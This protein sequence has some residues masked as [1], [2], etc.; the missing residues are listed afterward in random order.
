M[1]VPSALRCAVVLT[2]QVSLRNW[3]PRE[4]ERARAIQTEF[5]LTIRSAS[6]RQ[7]GEE[8]EA[9]LVSLW[10]RERTHVAA[11][12]DSVQRELAGK[13]GGNLSSTVSGSPLV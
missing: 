12:S 10:P 3:R 8:S 2:T 9:L 7:P 1:A 11:L 13:L 4:R 6:V 5:E